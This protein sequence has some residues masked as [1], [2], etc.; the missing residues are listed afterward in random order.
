MNYYNEFDR[1]AAAWLRELI[2]DKLTPAGDVDERSIADVTPQEL[3]GYTQCHFFA[4]IGGWPLALRLASWPDDRPVWTGSCPCQPYSSAGKGLGDKDPRNLW[5]VFFSLI[6]QCRPD[7]VFGEQVESAIRHG[8]LDGVQADL[9]GEGY[10]VGHCV[11]GA[12]SVGAPHIRQRLFW[13]GQSAQQLLNGSWDGGQG[14]RTEHSDASGFGGLAGTERNGGRADEPQR[15]PQ[16]GTA[17]RWTGS[18][19]ADTDQPRPQG[20]LERGGGS[21]ERLAGPGLPWNNYRLIPC[22][23]GKARR[24]EPGT[25]PLVNGLPK[26]MVYSGDPGLSV[27]ETGEARVMRLKGYGNAIMP[28]VAAE[29]IIATGLLG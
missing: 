17:D 24:L 12:H 19:L 22:R 6:R 13:V 11:L 15:G 3:A 10:A 2:A 5:P 27:N 18:G 16:R 20:R 28:A 7:A 8:W 14:G 29:F 21:R 25:P 4:G 26:G 9:E 1:N 23:D